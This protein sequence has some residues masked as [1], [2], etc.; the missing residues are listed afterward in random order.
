MYQF[1]ELN[2]IKQYSFLAKLDMVFNTIAVEKFLSTISVDIIQP[3]SLP[4][5]GPICHDRLGP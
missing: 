4:F 3:R 1:V 5:A 2:R